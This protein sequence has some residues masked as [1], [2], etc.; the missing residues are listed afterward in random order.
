MKGPEPVGAVEDIAIPGPAG[1]IAARTYRPAGPHGS[2]GSDGAILPVVVYVHGGGWVIADIDVYDAS[3]R[4]LANRSGAMVVAVEYRHAPEY[5]FPAAHD[6]VLAATS[7]IMANAAQLGGDPA[8]VAIAGES[9]GGNMAAATCIALAAQGGPAPVF[10]LL[11][12]P[13]TST[14]MDTVSYAE[15]ADAKPL[16]SGFMNWFFGQTIAS[17]ADL[18]DPRLNLL[19]VADMALAGLPPALV[20]TAER[21]PLRDEG[22]AFAERLRSAG[23]AVD[24]LRFEGVCHEFFG[25][26]AVLDQAAK[27]QEHAATALCSAFGAAVTSAATGAPTI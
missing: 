16:Y 4:G 24:A 14:A 27:A 9:A 19:G 3:C 7:W 8:R 5:P 1:D 21:D 17:V 23:V 6:D 2:D 11:I 25:A 13:V 12:Y 18:D 22:E 26:A 20:I 10:Q 15:A